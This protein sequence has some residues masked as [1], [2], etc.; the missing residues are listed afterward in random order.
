MPLNTGKNNSKKRNR[1]GAEGL[2]YSLSTNC[3]YDFKA[4]PD[5]EY[6]GSKWEHRVYMAVRQ[7]VPDEC[8]SLHEI[9]PMK[10]ATERYKPMGL[11]VDIV[12]R[13]SASHPWVPYLLID[14]KGEILPEFKR[15]VK[16]LEY[17]NPEAYSKLLVVG[18]YE[19][20]KIDQ[21]LSTIQLH[22]LLNFLQSHKLKTVS[23]V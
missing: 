19:P 14:P 17:F 16:L 22:T 13:P 1:H 6:F 18:D 10:P 15:N 9:I 21:Y 11:N 3:I 7:M 5:C 20:L 8:I 2:Y 12:T 4:L 23:I